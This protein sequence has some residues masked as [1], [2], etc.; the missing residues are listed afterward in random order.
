MK[1]MSTLGIL[2]MVER[3]GSG[4]TFGLTAQAIKVSGVVIKWKEMGYL[5]GLMGS[6]LKGSGR[7]LRCMER[8]ALDGWM[9]V[10]IKGSI[11]SIRS[12]GLGRWGILMGRC[13]WGKT[14]F[15]NFL[16]FMILRYWNHGIPHGKGT[17]IVPS[18][19]KKDGEWVN[20]RRMRWY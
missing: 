13:M 20:G 4:S 19:E 17:V 2:K 16:K 10:I 14:F 8:V 15:K 18:G 12:M 5:L 9:V 7:I 6:I 1:V 3:K 11:T